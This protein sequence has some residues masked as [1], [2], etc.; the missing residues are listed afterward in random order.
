MH[1]SLT[2]QVCFEGLRQA[3]SRLRAEQTAGSP[4]PTPPH[5]RSLGCSS[6]LSDCIRRL[7]PQLGITMLLKEGWSVM[8]GREEG[9]A[10]LVRAQPLETP[11]DARPQPL[12]TCLLHQKGGRSALSS[13]AVPPASQCLWPCTCTSAEAATCPHPLPP[14]GC[15]KAG[16]GQGRLPED[17]QW[18]GGLYHPFPVPTPDH[19]QQRAPHQTECKGKLTAVDGTGQHVEQ[20]S[21]EETHLPPT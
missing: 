5:P 7:P 12:L 2:F 15:L 16:A 6:T 20:S 1:L 11:D 13:E 18:M 21:L 10:T 4:A 3:G 19:M 17:A 14:G 8:W 9:E